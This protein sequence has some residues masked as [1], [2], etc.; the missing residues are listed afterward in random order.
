MGRAEIQLEQERT[1]AQLNLEKDKTDLMKLEA[2]NKL[3]EKRIDAEAAAQPFAQHAKSFISALNETGVTIN[4]GVGLY[5]ILKEAEH[6]NIDTENLAGG[7]AT[8]F[9]TSSDVK[10]N[11]RDLNLGGD[12]ATADHAEDHLDL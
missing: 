4:N 8:L 3:M 9:L 12:N 7:K 1:Q 2:E 6:H 5:R 11:I 10:L